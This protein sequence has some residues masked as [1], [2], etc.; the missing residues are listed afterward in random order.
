MTSESRVELE[1]YLDTVMPFVKNVEEIIP[2]IIAQKSLDMTIGLAKQSPAFDT[3]REKKIME[4]QRKIEIER[5]IGEKEQKKTT[6]E[7]DAFDR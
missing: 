2:F 6:I 5:M 3:V 7:D 4:E 1:H